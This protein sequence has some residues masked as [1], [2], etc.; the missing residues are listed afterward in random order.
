MPTKKSST[1]LLHKCC[2]RPPLSC[3]RLPT[4]CAPPRETPPCPATATTPFLIP[5]ERAVPPPRVLPDESVLPGIPQERR[6]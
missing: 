2:I 3:G 1:N 6:R 4:C 5:D